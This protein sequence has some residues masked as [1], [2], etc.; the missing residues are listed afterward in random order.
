MFQLNSRVRV[1]TDGNKV[2][3]GT[4]LA[5]D[6]HTNLVISDTVI[7]S[8]RRSLGLCVMRGANIRSVEVLEQPSNE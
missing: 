1:S 8:E 2:F 7:E 3:L 4:L 6:D 5:Y